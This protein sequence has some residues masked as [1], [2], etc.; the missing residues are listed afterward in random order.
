MDA[1]DLD[2]PENLSDRNTLQINGLFGNDELES[3]FYSKPAKLKQKYFLAEP[4]PFEIVTLPNGQE[5]KLAYGKI[6]NVDLPDLEI[7]LNF[8]NRYEIAHRE[9][10]LQKKRQLRERAASKL[11]FHYKKVIPMISPRMAEGWNRWSEEILDLFLSHKLHRVL[12]GSGGCGKSAM[13]ALLLYIKW[14]VLPHKR[15][16]VIAS[17]VVKE[18]SARVF[19]YIKEIHTN[20]PKSYY[21]EFKIHDAADGKGIFCL[22]TNKSDGK[23]IADD[24]ACIVTLP[25]KVNVKAADL[26]GN[27]LGKHP[28]DILIIAFDE[29]QEMP[30][31]I[32]DMKI[33]LNWYTNPNVE[34]HAWGNPVPVEF[35]AK[36]S[37]DL[38][39]QLGVGNLGIQT[40]RKLEK[41]ADKTDRWGTKNTEVLRLSMLDSP[42]DDPDEVNNYVFEKETGARLLRLR[43][44]G[45]KDTVKRIAS[46]SSPT[47]PS[48]YSQ[49]L[50]FPY[51]DFQGE[52][53]QGC[54]T[55]YIIKE[56]NKYP[57][58][59][60]SQNEKLEWFMGVDPSLTGKGD[61]CAIVCGAVGMML[62]GRR[63]IDLVNGRYCRK[64]IPVLSGDDMNEE[65]FV[66]TT[67]EVMWGL[68][69][70]LGIPLR[71]IAIETFSIGEVLRYAML[72]HIEDGKWA[73]DK[74]RG[75]MFHAV[76]PMQNTTDR[77]MFKQLGRMQLA[78]EMCENFSTELWVSFRCAVENRQ[79]FNVPEFMA[80]EFYNRMLAIPG[81]KT[82]YR[83]ERKDDMKK[84]GVRSPSFGDA[85]CNMLE[86]MR[87][88]G[89]FSYKYYNMAAYN[90]KFGKTYNMQLERRRTEDKM[91]LV[92]QMLGVQMDISPSRKSKIRPP[93]DFDLV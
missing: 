90:E 57:L 48:W 73:R 53:N 46:E 40:L 61:D 89:K 82:K 4:K 84:R 71:N 45:G 85:A 42:K 64:V 59:W 33:F 13:Y 26:G 14:R 67:I 23:K 7:E 60:K 65:E 81:Q 18:A 66:D 62:D 75:E 25:V 86:I 74:D 30:G 91:G 54:L 29:G 3:A 92:S 24:R 5:A 10:L 80:Q 28:E 50:G 83:I 27:L 17:K 41:N 38:L 68:S 22:M 43:F 16:V 32:L 44:L 35:H 78:K 39:F 63:G 70:E 72:Q 77:L 1:K 88:R 69:Q 19:S 58:I 55:P 12:W 21:H 76:N 87:I 9:A 6:F 47:S 2:N 34:I 15:M 31:H 36:E 56:T 20:A 93:F 11:K 37:W 49:V 51:I 8:I 52:R 79:L